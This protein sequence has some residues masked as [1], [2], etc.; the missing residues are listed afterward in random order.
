[1]D[2]QLATTR[3]EALALKAFWIDNGG[4]AKAIRCTKGWLVLL[5]ST[6]TN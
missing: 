1:M 3:T 4:K 5:F 2:I 6:T